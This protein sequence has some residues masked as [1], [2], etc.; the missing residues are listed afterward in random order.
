MTQDF[1]YGSGLEWAPGRKHS[2]LLL[3]EAQHLLQTQL[4][5]LYLQEI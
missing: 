1:I 2:P 5:T 4:P 3:M